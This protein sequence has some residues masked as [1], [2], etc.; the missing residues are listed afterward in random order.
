MTPFNFP[1]QGSLGVLIYSGGMDSTALLHECKESIALCVSFNYGSKHNQRE[2]TYAQDNC[3]SLG[4]QHETIELPFVNK[5]FRSELLLSGGEIPE[6]DYSKENLESTVVPFRNGIMLSIAAGLAESNRLSF[7]M[8]ANHGS[9][10]EIYPDCRPSFI[11]A[12]HRAIFE[13]SDRTVSLIAP[14]THLDKRAIALRARSL[15]V[16]LSRS[17]S[18]YKGGELHCGTCSTC[19]ERKRALDGFDTTSYSS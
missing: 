13:G 3:R 15:G 4:I 16:D 19:R 8:L 5:F 6:G 11:E 18:C 17:W 12:M 2:L 1:H 7:I 10:H 9:D 14:Y